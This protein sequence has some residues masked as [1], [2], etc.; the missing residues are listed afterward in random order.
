M[1]TDVLKCLGCGT[2]MNQEKRHGVTIDRCNNCGGLWFDVEEVHSYL[3]AHPDVP[4]SYKPDP[5]DF[6]SSCG[7]GGEPCPCCDQTA[8]RPGSFRGIQYQRCDWCGGLYVGRGQIEEIVR[9]GVESSRTLPAAAAAGTAVAAAETVE[10]LRPLAERIG[11]TASEVGVVLLNE[12]VEAW[13]DPHSTLAGDA[14]GLIFSFV[15][16]AIADA[17]G[18]W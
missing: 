18:G 16:D 9:Q 5:N 2:L 17:I 10:N 12:M 13:S 15:A 4:S 8:L 3:Q 6:K 14:L 7:E 1:D 11:D